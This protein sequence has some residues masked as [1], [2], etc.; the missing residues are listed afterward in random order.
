VH[1]RG[2][3]GTLTGA[4]PDSAEGGRLPQ[5]A[6]T[7]AGPGVRDG[8]RYWVADDVRLTAEGAPLFGDVYPADEPFAP[9]MIAVPS[10]SHTS[11]PGDHHD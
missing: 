7:V 11:A 6:F 9:L 10:P 3:D 1:L 4:D 5:V 8:A 2:T